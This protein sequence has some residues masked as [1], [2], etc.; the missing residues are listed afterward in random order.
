[1][2]PLRIRFRL[3]GPALMIGDIVWALDMSI[4]RICVHS[5]EVAVVI[6][7][8]K[9]DVSNKRLLM[10]RKS[11]DPD[12]ALVPTIPSMRL[13]GHPAIATRR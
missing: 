7:S 8:S 5:E 3:V 10:I 4:A 9:C 12:G 2:A 6:E 13:Q 11:R 1:M